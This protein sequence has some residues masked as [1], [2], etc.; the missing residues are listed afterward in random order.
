[1]IMLGKDFFMNV[2]KWCFN[3]FNLIFKV[4]W[5]V[6]YDYK[7]ILFGIVLN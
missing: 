3:L 7:E 5:K 1:M 6:F 2:Y 4:V